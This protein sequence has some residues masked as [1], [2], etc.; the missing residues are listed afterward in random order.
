LKATHLLIVR[1]GETDWN[2]AR[3]FQG[4][5]D[6]PLNDTGRQ[7]AARLARRL[8]SMSIDAIYSSDLQRCLQT[9]APTAQALGLA[10]SKTQTLRERNYGLFEGLTLP[11][12]EERYPQVRAD[13][14]RHDPDYAIPGGESTR[15]LFQRIVSAIQMIVASHV[16][17]TLLIVTHGGVLDMIYRAATH[18]P[19]EQPRRCLI[20]NAALNE[21]CFDEGQLSILEWADDAHLQAEFQAQ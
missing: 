18:Q 15:V 4:S 9:V 19:L 20:P 11:E 21:L 7:Q 17:Q 2:R 16:G 1:H 13:W 14:A 5:I 3:R 6:I 12:I 8:S 10:V